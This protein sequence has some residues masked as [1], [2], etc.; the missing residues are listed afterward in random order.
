MQSRTRPSDGHGSLE[1]CEAWSVSFRISSQVEQQDFGRPVG[2]DR[3]GR[4][5][6]DGGPVA[7]RTAA[8]PFRSTLAPQDLQ[9]G[10]AAGRRASCET[11]WPAVQR[12]EVQPGVLADRQ[13]A[14]APVGRGDQAQ[15]VA[16]LLLGEGPLLVAR[17]QPLPLGQQPD[18]V[19]VDRLGLPR[20]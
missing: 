3:Q 5:V 20:G 7:R 6:A 15:P 18:L 14:V 8:C 2:P 11:S 16:P 4:L 19:E 17:L 12:G 1:A 13:R 10:V 9:P